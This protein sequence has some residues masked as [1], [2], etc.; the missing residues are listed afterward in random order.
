MS[1]QKLGSKNITNVWLYALLPLVSFLF[2]LLFST[3]TSPI[4]K[5]WYFWYGGDSAIF[6][7]MGY[8]IIY[9]K[10][11]Y[12]DF[13]DHKGP[14]LF[15]TQAL[16]ILISNDWGILILQTISLSVTF[17][18]SIK[19]I[20]LYNIGGKSHLFIFGLVL[21]ILFAYFQ[22]GNTSEE[23]CLPY[24]SIA[25]YIYF[26]KKTTLKKL[27][28]TECFFIGLC[29][30]CIFMIRANSSAPIVGL[31]IYS[32]YSALIHKDKKEIIDITIYSLLGLITILF[33]FIILF[34]L[35]YGN[36]CTLEMLY[37]TFLFNIEYLHTYLGTPDIKQVLIFYLPI[38]LMCSA[39]LLCLK[40][41][42]KNII[43]SITTAYILT[44]ISCGFKC[45]EHYVIIFVPLFLISFCLLC[46]N[47]RIALL[48][49]TCLIVIISLIAV[50]PTI[51]CL[52]K[53][54]NHSPKEVSYKDDFKRFVSV[55]TNKEKQS[56][57]NY[58]GS[59]PVYFFVEE[60][61]LQCSRIAFPTHLS[62]SSKIKKYEI[63]HGIKDIK[64]L[65]ILIKEKENIYMDDMS[66]LK[67]NY[68]I[69]D[70]I[71]DKNQTV[72]CYKRLP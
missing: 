60:K 63:E 15:F 33:F 18:Y 13:F 57:Y 3:T 61:M 6:Q 44:T 49:S 72:Y 70:S 24:L 35:L 58:H 27:G 34:I 31:L 66:L 1:F 25:L 62:V 42:N 20:N 68:I 53:R 16:G 69:S 14:L 32:F 40:Q 67:E 2:V 21:F 41:H 48:I 52:I 54:Y 9:G 10:I 47:H 56:I 43:T 45:C 4:Y 11:P 23:W 17:Y 50:K 64:P 59:I 71:Y 46:Q 38:V 28:K 37:A 12:I 22:R 51:N 7:E 19:I 5:G 65:W 26:R 55:M 30:G 8:C 36:E 29:V 39:T